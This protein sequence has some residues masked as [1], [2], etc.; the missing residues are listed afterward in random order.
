MK[1]FLTVLKW[2]AIAVVAIALA[3]FSYVQLSWEK[4]YE[5]PMPDI[6]AS[7]DSAVIAHGKYLAFGP[8]HCASCHVPMDKMA[9]VDQGIEMPLIGGM[10]MELAGLGLLRSPN[11]TPDKETGIGNMTDAQIARALRFGVG[12]QGHSLFPIMPF[13]EL[14]DY[15]LTAIVSFLRTQTPVKNNVPK[16][17]YGFLGKALH[18]FGVFK[19]VGPVNTPPQNVVADSGAQYG[20]YLA[21]SVANCRGCHT[22]R[23]LQTGQYTGPDFAGGFIFPPDK[24]TKGYAFVSP[25]ITPDPTTGV[26][27]GW[28]EE[29]FIKRFR[30]GRIHEGSHMPWGTFSRMS[31]RDLKALYAFLTSIKPVENKIEKVVFAP[32]EQLPL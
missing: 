15:D 8:A 23:D 18:T 14:S 7:T 30:D 31:D 22:S 10:E 19:P 26:M 9:Q 25:N 24:F 1:T 5:A 27:A 16:T 6:Q 3:F 28:S 21:Y 29:A 12:H 32:G 13:Q 4:V 11:I 17:E 20:K 2:G